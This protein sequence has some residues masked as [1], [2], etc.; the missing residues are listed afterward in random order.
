VQWTKRLWGL[1]WSTRIRAAPQRP[2]VYS[3][4]GSAPSSTGGASATA[5]TASGGGTILSVF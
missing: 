4:V 3:M 2:Q 5:A 1:L